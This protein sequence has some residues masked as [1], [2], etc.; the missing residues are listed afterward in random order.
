MQ[1]GDVAARAGVKL[2]EAEEALKALAYDTQGALEVQLCY[3]G[4]QN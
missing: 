1:I 4:F 2:S 3:L